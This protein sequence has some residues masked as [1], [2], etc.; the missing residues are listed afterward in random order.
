MQREEKRA[1]RTKE[2]SDWFPRDPDAPPTDLLELVR[3]GL[4]LSENPDAKGARFRALPR[5][6]QD[7][8]E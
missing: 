6:E 8:E 4:P 7:D 5:D 2:F 1:D 3:F